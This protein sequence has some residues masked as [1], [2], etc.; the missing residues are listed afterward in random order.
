MSSTSH[1]APP[2]EGQCEHEHHHVVTTHINN[3]EVFLQAGRY[4]VPTFKKLAGVPQADDL[5]E[6]VECKLRPI[7]DDATLHIKGCEIFISH[8]KDG[9]S[10]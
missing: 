5:D 7:P 2:E 1:D 9:G 6:L 4:D 3:Q 8:V 10:S